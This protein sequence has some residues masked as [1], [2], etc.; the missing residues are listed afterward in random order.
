MFSL[1]TY[2]PSHLP[3]S[4]L[5]KAFKSSHGK[6]LTV[7]VEV[8]IILYICPP[9]KYHKWSPL[10]SED[11]VACGLSAIVFL[12]ECVQCRGM[13]LNYGGGNLYGS[14][15]AAIR[16]YTLVPLLF[17]LLCKCVRVCRQCGYR[18]LRVGQRTGEL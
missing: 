9:P 13:C 4:S 5:L 1:K 12:C 8:K 15:V 14:Q 10:A 16:L 3:L 11:C 7:R 18:I 2:Y 17:E 6:T